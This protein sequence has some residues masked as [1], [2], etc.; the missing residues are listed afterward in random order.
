MNPAACKPL[1]EATTCDSQNG[2]KAPTR[3]GMGCQTLQD[4]CD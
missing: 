2:K 3:F 1:F 4:T